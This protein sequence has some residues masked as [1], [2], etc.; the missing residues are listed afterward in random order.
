MYWCYVKAA[1]RGGDAAAELKNAEA[2]AALRPA[3]DFMTLDVY[4]VLKRAGKGD[5]AQAIFDL[6]Y[7]DVKRR[8]SAAGNDSGSFNRLAWPCARCGQHL[9]EALAL[10]RRAVT[11]EPKNPAF[12]DTEAEVLFA[13]G[14]AKEAIELENHA[15]E[16][17]EDAD[18]PPADRPIP[19]R[20]HR[21]A[22]RGGMT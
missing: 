9:D 8:L 20:I 3:S 7:D 2:L 5:D 13:L 19:R 21:S 10:S 16:L 18:L 4:P 6:A 14:Q 1:R 22:R 15:L 17:A 11:M 12:I